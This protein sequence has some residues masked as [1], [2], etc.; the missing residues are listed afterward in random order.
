MTPKT[1]E[2]ILELGLNKYSSEASKLRSTIGLCNLHLQHL[3]KREVCEIVLWGS[4][5]PET[6]G[7]IEFFEQEKS[8]EVKQTSRVL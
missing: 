8:G 7:E 3:K 4:V 5:L 6:I 2:L 1:D